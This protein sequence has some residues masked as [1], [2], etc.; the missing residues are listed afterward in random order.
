MT[1]REIYV[2][3]EYI[4]V[5]SVGYEPKGT[6]LLRFGEFKRNP[7]F[8]MALKIGLLC[9]KS[10][11]IKEERFL[12]LMETLQKELW[13]FWQPKQKW[14]KKVAKILGNTF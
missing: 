11:L 4:F 9:N 1:T 6:F 5:E 13:L 12:E 3:R 10:T 7:V 8:E 2:N 14:I